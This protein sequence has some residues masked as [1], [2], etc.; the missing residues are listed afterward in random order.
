MFD[1]ME[2]GAIDLPKHPK[3]DNPNDALT[4]YWQ[5][6]IA[7][8]RAMHEYIAERRPMAVARVDRIAEGLPASGNR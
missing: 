8:D 3:S 4:L 5:R 1:Y 6:L 2:V 7:K